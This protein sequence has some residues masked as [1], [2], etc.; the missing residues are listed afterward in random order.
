MKVAASDLLDPESI[1]LLSKPSVGR[2]LFAALTEWA[3]IIVAL[4]VAIRWHH[5][6]VW[7]PA[8]ILIGSR[9]NA[10]GILTH[11][12]THKNAAESLFWNDLLSNW[13]VSYP[14]GVSAE[15]SGATELARCKV[16]RG[17]VGCKGRIG[18]RRWKWAMAAQWRALGS[19]RNEE[20][21]RSWCCA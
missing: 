9:Q 14:I 6:Y 16:N 5:W 10:L 20:G 19:N 15:R 21:R 2:W 7:L 1:D 17:M 4:A 3:I 11:E 18:A 13:L 8:A 12:G